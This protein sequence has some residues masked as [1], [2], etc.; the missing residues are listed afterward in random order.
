MAAGVPLEATK[1]HALL[2][3]AALVFAVFGVARE[4]GVS[5]LKASVLAVV[6]AGNPILIVQLFTRMNDGL[7]G[8]SLALM[9][10]FSTLWVLRRQRW[11]LIGVIA[12]LVFA[13]NLKFSG[14]PMAVF[15]CAVVCGLA[16]WRRGW[17]QAAEVAGVLAA[18]GVLGVMLL[19]AHPY[20]TNTISHGHPF[21]PLLGDKPVDIIGTNL[22]PA[23]EKIGPVERIGAS[24][25]GTTASGYDAPDT[26]LKLPLMIKPSE[27][28]NAGAYDTRVAGFGPFFSA[29]LVLALVLAAALLVLRGRSVATRVLLAGSGAFVVLGLIMPEAWWA[30]YVP[31]VWWAP[32]LVAAAAFVSSGQ[33]LRIA[34]WALAGVMAL[35]AAIVAVSSAKYVLERNLDIRSQLAEMQA[36]PQKL[37]LH[38]GELHARLALLGSLK[39][40]VRVESQPLQGCTVTPL[41]GGFPHVPAGYCACP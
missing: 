1:S 15:F 26:Q 13:L 28:T 8:T 41:A 19:G 11:A 24:Y 18:A 33:K 39:D 30:R 12:P 10:L 27:I 38:V 5:K 36:S 23:L 34:G 25:F 17:L 22:P 40:R 35:N 14:V 21:Y 29:A 3:L 7:L 16:L 9:L 2:L 32:V 4:F 6:A 31:Q 20:I 37:C